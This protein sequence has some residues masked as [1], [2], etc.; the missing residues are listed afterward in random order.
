MAAENLVRRRRGRRRDR[1]ASMRPRRMAAEN[2]VDGAAGGGAGGGFNEAAA[3][4]RG[5]RG[6]VHVLGRRDLA[7][8]R[9]RRMAA[10]NPRGKRRSGP[11]PRGLQ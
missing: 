10:E 11:T 2:A 6:L 9:P 5:K 3:H 4:G 7:S 8:M 1:G